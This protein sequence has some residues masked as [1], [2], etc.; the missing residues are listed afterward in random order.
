MGIV[1]H[2]SL[3]LAQGV[4]NYS[5]RSEYEHIGCMDDTSEAECSVTPRS[6]LSAA[7]RSCPRFLEQMS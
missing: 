6:R 1:N 3:L 4:S 2:S 7:T 5:R